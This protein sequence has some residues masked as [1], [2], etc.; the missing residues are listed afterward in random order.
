VILAGSGPTLLS[1]LAC[2]TESL[3]YTLHMLQPSLYFAHLTPDNSGSQ[4][5]TTRP[6][7][8]STQRRSPHLRELPQQMGESEGSHGYAGRNRAREGATAAVHL[9]AA[10]K[11]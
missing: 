2:L 3:P 8:V 5:L 1:P 7:Q 11:M 6:Q 10:E 4:Y 9:Q